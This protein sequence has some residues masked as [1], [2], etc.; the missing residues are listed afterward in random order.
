MYV[1]RLLLVPGADGREE[2]HVASVSDQRKYIRRASKPGHPGDWVQSEAVNHV[3]EDEG[4]GENCRD[5]PHPGERVHESVYSSVLGGADA[6]PPVELRMDG[7]LCIEGSSTAIKSGLNGSKP[8]CHIL[9]VG[10]V[11]SS[12]HYG[13]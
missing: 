13:G 2:V 10:Q 8:L 1:W 7:S 5:Y 4:G 6:H 9:D 12:G 11:E 3:S